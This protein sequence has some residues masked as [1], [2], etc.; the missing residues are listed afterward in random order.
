MLEMSS[1]HPELQAQSGDLQTLATHNQWFIRSQQ[2][3]VR[4]HPVNQ[5]AEMADRPGCRRGAID[6]D[7]VANLVPRLSASD[8]WSMLRGH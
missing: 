6:A 7:H 8:L 5:P 2:R 4:V 3:T 1:S